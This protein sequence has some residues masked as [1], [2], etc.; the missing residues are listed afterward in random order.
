MGEGNGALAKEGLPGTEKEGREGR[1]LR[2]LWLF[3]PHISEGA[4]FERQL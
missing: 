2:T 1:G 3:L 4:G